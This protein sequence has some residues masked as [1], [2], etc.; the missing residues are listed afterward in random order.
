MAVTVAG[1]GAGWWKHNHLCSD[2]VNNSPGEYKD[3]TQ[4]A[5]ND[6]VTL[7]HGRCSTWWKSGIRGAVNARW[8]EVAALSHRSTW[9]WRPVSDQAFPRRSRT[10]VFWS[11]NGRKYRKH[12]Q[13]YDETATSRTGSMDASFSHQCFISFEYPGTFFD[14]IRRNDGSDGPG[15]HIFTVT[16][17]Y[18]H[19]CRG[20]RSFKDISDIL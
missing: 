18:Q 11:L 1:G 19:L 5:K 17:R 12:T 20:K 3:E 15:L 2:T 13:S 6:N 16:R 4:E 8:Q 9:A 14:G 7:H 10:C